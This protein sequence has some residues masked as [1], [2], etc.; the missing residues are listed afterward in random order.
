MG[1]LAGNFVFGHFADLQ[2]LL[3]NVYIFLRSLIIVSRVL[4]QDQGLYV[5]NGSL[6]AVSI[7]TPLAISDFHY[8]YRAF[9]ARRP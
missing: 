3:R 1:N 7:F 2:A 6:K 9:R 4:I 5:A 8:R